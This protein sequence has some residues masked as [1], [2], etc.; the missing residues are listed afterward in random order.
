MRHA[1]AKQFRSPGRAAGGFAS[2][3][4]L[5][6]AT[7]FVVAFLAV[8]LLCPERDLWPNVVTAIVV[9]VVVNSAA[10]VGNELLVWLRMR[11]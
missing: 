7:T 10:A 5:F 3:G 2:F 8:T 4:C 9:G 1:A 11:E 6:G